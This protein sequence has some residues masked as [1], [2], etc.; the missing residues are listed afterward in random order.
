MSDIEGKC[1]TTSDYNKFTDK[2][3]D[4]KIKDK[5]LFNKSDIINSSDLEKDKIVKLKTHDSSLFT[6][7]SYSINDGSQNLSIFLPIFNTLTMPAI[8]ADTI[9]EWKSRGLSNEKIRPPIMQ[10]IVF[11]QN[12]DG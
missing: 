12:R 5:K 1:F 2:I 4:V 9:V 11:L 7:Q 8:L 6:G 3:L 10:I